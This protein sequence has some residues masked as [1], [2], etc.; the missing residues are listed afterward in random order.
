[1]D[2]KTNLPIDCAEYIFQHLSFENLLKCTL[3]CPQ[4]NEYI[5][6]TRSCM[7]R[8]SITRSPYLRYYA[9]LEKIL[10]RSNRSYVCFCHGLDEKYQIERLLR[11]RQWKSVTINRY[12][13]DDYLDY[14]GIF[15][16]SVQNLVLRFASAPHFKT[17]DLKFP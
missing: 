5:G 13:G 6:K 2:P 1:M 3:V 4:W 14:F 10:D 11:K 16:N 7:K 9:D 12:L 8:I 15:E 17:C